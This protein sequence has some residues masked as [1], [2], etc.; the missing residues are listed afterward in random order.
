M[1][2]IVMSSDDAFP[3]ACDTLY[4]GETFILKAVFTDNLALG[5]YSIDIHHNFDHHT[6]STEVTECHLADVKTPINPFTLIQD[7]DIADGQSIYET[8][9]EISLP[10]SDGGFQYDEGDYHF[11]LKLVD[12]T[13]WSALYG[14]GVKVVYR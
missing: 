7:Y 9:L 13:G 6:H 12:Q 5:S 8:D 11:H 1:P 3:E 14:V 10:S 2:E 4:F